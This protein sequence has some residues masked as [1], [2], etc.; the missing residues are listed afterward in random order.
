MGVGWNIEQLWSAVEGAPECGMPGCISAPSLAPLMEEGLS[1]GSGS[2]SLEK[3]FY[4]W[5]CLKWWGKG[6]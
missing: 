2:L 1:P 5:V 6:G 4:A 3:I